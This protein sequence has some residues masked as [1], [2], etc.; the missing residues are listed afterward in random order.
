MTPH[1]DQESNMTKATANTEIRALDDAELDMISGG[2]IFGDIAH[3]V[4]SAVHT[5]EH[6]ASTVV[7]N[8]VPVFNMAASASAPG[9]A[10]GI[11]MGN[12]PFL[13]LQSIFHF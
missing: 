5:V 11:L 1:L 3:G 13:F 7:N 4:S 9:T 6:A 2:S 12:L 8:I 10:A